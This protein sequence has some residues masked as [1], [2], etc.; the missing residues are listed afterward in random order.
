MTPSSG[1]TDDEK[2]ALCVAMAQAGLVERGEVQRWVTTPK[3]NL[4]GAALHGIAL[5][6]AVNGEARRPLN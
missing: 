4:W 3:G 1:F 5:A 2:E 6:A